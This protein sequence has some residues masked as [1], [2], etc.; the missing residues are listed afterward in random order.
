MN[1]RKMTGVIGTVLA[2]ALL[3][4]P[5]AWSATEKAVPVAVSPVGATAHV[6]PT[7]S[8]SSVKLAEHYELAVHPVSA[9]GEVSDRP[10]LQARLPRGATSWTPPA[11]SCLEP[12]NV[13]GWS[14]RAVDAKGEGKWSDAVLI[15]T[16]APLSPSF[17]TGH[18]GPFEAI[19]NSDLSQ[20]N[21]DELVLDNDQ[22]LTPPAMT[23][24]TSQATRVLPKPGSELE[25]SPVS[26][27]S[28]DGPTTKSTYAGSTASSGLKINGQIL[29]VD[30][31]GS[32]RVWGRAREDNTVYI[33]GSGFPCFNNQGNKFGLSRMAVDWGSARE[34]C[35]AGTWVCGL[36]ELLSCNTARPDDAI[37]GLACDGSVL[38]FDSAQHRGWTIQSSTD[39]SGIAWREDGGAVG[40]NVCTSLPV[41]CCW[42]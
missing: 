30:E 4:V 34:A 35:P 23:G 18:I 19:P 8:W 17:N 36:F 29:T 25:P 32:P 15:R 7:F 20:A 10:A 21:R 16:K 26:K 12:K 6:C 40:S 5:V 38:N 2:L 27:A 9:K 22:I 33:T 3:T 1:G 14:I 41:W 24:G 37:D 42:D 13:Y 39:H 31:Q 11:G 28:I